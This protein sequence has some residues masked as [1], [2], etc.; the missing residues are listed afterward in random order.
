M[1][2]RLA[3]FFI[4]AIALVSA[5]SLPALAA[6]VVAPS[7]V[8]VSNSTNHS[9][10]V[11]WT[12]NSVNETDFVI[13][14][15][16]DGSNIIGSMSV[17]TNDK[18]NTGGHQEV[19]FSGLDPNTQYYFKVS[20]LDAD[21]NAISTPTDA[22]API[23]TKANPP[24][25]PTVGVISTDTIPLTL[26]ENG[27]PS[28]TVYSVAWAD[29]TDP[30]NVVGSLLS[31]N[32]FAT[33]NGIFYQTAADWNFTGLVKGLQPGHKYSFRI[34]SYNNGDHNVED[35]YVNTA[36]LETLGDATKPATPM[37]I[38][39]RGAETA[40]TLEW[41]QGNGGNEDTFGVK[42]SSDG[43]VYGA[44]V[45]K[46]IVGNGAFDACVGENGPIAGC[47]IYQIG[48]LTP[49]SPYYISLSSKNQNGDSAEAYPKFAYTPAATPKAP[50]VSAITKSSFNFTIDTTD[51]NPANTKYIAYVYNT[52]I[53]KADTQVV[54]A[55]GTLGGNDYAAT[56]AQW[57]TKTITGLLANTQYSIYLQAINVGFGYEGVDYP[58][59][60]SSVV[61]NLTTVDDVV[62][63]G[64]NSGG[65]S[66]GGSGM[67]PLVVVVPT[68]TVSVI[69]GSGTTNTTTVQTNAPA[70]TTTDGQ[71]LGEKVSRIAELISLTKF[72]EK[73]ANVKELQTL[74]KEA[75][76][77]AKSFKP[78]N[79]YGILTRA[80]VQ[81][82]QADQLTLDELIAK[83][84]F[85]QS[86]YMVYRLQTEL[87]K[88][89]FMPKKW[90]ATYNFGPITKAGVAK[91]LASK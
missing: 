80:A 13:Y 72:G 6:D 36:N 1:L 47:F 58:A 77:F 38:S 54:Q 66:G 67:A 27:N 62:D 71:V 37:F 16:D 14:L 61:T 65:G 15:S 24:G 28:T 40:L 44:P 73:S 17:N 10:T 84:K 88:L 35:G 41:K 60:Y 33:P 59:S 89:G 19:E 11:G 12:D 74:L 83:T 22:N 76:Y 82:Y 70:D 55:D 87:A 8:V 45:I 51:G 85:G 5:Y 26:N 90:K 20:A 64:G 91:Y 49:N 39:L 42:Y 21:A 31:K 53:H 2:K 57:G 29:Y 52:N 34:S 32:G 3:V 63:N 4:S 78:T 75:G 18:V 23:Y 25:N 79:F 86:N 43:I 56:A 68:T 7:N 48:G 46:P 81:K 50:I 69:T 30:N 9:V